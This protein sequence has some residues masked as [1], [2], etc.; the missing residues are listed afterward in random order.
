ME[1]EHLFD[2]LEGQLAAEWEAQRVA[3]DAE[4]ERLRIAKLALHERLRSTVEGAAPVVLELL[5]GDRW[6]VTPEAL[7]ADWLGVCA[8]GDPRLRIVPLDA[9]ESVAVDHGTMLTSLRVQTSAPALRERMTFGFVLRDLARRRIP[10]QLGMRSGTSLHGT[11]DRAGADHLDLAL[12]DAG[13]QRRART[14]QG[15]RI[16]PFAAVLWVRL[17]SGSADLLG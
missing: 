15:F 6:Q 4:S 14:V 17:T 9:V 3:L 11:V 12:H 7:G 8:E 10:V 16:I 5:S 1:W 2:D 13:E